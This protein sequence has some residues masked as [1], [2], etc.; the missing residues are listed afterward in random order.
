VQ[1]L[2]FLEKGEA[3]FVLPKYKNLIYIIIEQGDFFGI[4]DLAPD[5]E[6]VE[7]DEK[8]KDLHIKKRDF[9]V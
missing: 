6:I 2:Y 9:T 7:N 1:F 8:P 4:M 5:H 3:G